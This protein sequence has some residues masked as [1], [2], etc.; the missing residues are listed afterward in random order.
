MVILPNFN[1]FLRFLRPSAEL[2]DVK[3]TLIDLAL[4]TLVVI[5]KFDTNHILLMVYHSLKDLLN[6]LVLQYC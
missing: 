3:L 4:F 2:L 1:T 5:E 6:F